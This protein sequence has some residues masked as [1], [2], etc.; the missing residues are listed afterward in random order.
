[1]ARFFVVHAVLHESL[2]YALYQTAVHL[3]FHNHGVDD[4]AE[5]VDCGELVDFGDAR[6]RINF[7]FADVSA[8]RESEV[9]GVVERC[10]VEAWLQLVQGVVVRHISCERNAAKWDFLV[11]AFD[12]EFTVGKFDISIA[13]F[14]EVSRNFLG[15]GLNLVKGTH[16]GRA[17]NRNRA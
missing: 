13:G 1:M 11:S 2:A 8:C 6:F 5:V 12:A 17:S 4:G 15:L 16:D 3:A 10:F 14:H 9:G 7:D